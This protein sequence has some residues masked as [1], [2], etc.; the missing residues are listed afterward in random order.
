ME[1]ITTLEYNKADD[2]QTRQ[3]KNRILVDREVYCCF[4]YAMSELQEKEVISFDDIE[5]Q[6]ETDEEIK[7]NHKYDLKGLSE[8]EIKEYVEN[9]K[10]RGENIK[11]IYEYWI[12]SEWLYDKLKELN[13]PVLEWG[14]LNIWGRT[15]T[16][17]AICLDYTMDEVRKT[18]N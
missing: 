4:S 17:Q 14:N 15:C 5:N 6:Y 13:E 7:E 10:D 12:V 2:E 9:V 16:G 1:K 8:E 18:F 3:E 11:D